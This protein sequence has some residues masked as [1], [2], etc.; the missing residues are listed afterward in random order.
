MLLFTVVSCLV[1]FRWDSFRV[2]DLVP[3]PDVTESS[4]VS[5]FAKEN[6]FSHL[7]LDSDVGTSHSDVKT[8]V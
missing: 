2:G 5:S 4:S 6:D 1:L 8:N 3:F 7:N